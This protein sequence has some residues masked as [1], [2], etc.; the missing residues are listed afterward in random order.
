MLIRNL[1]RRRLM[2]L[3]ELA[4]KSGVS[5]VN[6]NRYELGTVEPKVF[7]AYKIARA[8][9]CTVEDLIMD[10]IEGSVEVQHDGQ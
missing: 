10:E 7:N 6:I 1:R 4:E 9:D 5:R 2:T 8:L 3:E